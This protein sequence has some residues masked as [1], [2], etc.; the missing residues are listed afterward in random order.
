MQIRAL[1]GFSEDTIQ[2]YGRSYSPLSGYSRN[3]TTL[4]SP[5]IPIAG[6]QDRRDAR[7]ER[8]LLKSLKPGDKVEVI[9]PA[10]GQKKWL[11]VENAQMLANMLSKGFTFIRDLRGNNTEQPA[12]H[13]PSKELEPKI[14]KGILFLLL[15]IGA[16]AIYKNFK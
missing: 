7:A 9:D 16:Y 3:C 2:K 4:G 12:E 11:T 14:Q 1:T 6:R 13:T 10:T 15:G 5:F 8:K